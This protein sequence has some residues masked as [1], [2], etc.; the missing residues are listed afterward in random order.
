MMRYAQGGGGWLKPQEMAQRIEAANPNASPR[1]KFYAMKAAM[2]LMTT[3]GQEQFN[4]MMQV[5]RFQQQKQQHEDT[6]HQ[7][8][9]ME[10]H[11]LEAEQLREDRYLRQQPYAQQQMQRAR[12]ATKAQTNVDLRMDK[13]AGHI[14]ALSEVAK[15]VAITG[16]VTFDTWLANAR[17][18]LGWPSDVYTQYKTQLAMLQAEM[19]AMSQQ[20]LGSLTVSAREDAKQLANGIL[21][22]SMLRSIG[23]AVKIEGTIT[24]EASK[25]IIDRANRNFDSYMKSGGRIPEDAEEEPAAAAPQAQRPRAADDKGNVVE[26][27][28]QNWVPVPKGP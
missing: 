27:D 9:R 2:G 28:G 8:E 24:K 14:A 20:T 19:G 21:T 22:P 5:M 3:G 18:A 1:Q 25:K 26:W 11:R 17:A 6:L 16:N 13:V 12:D 4:R 7:Q 10:R 23:E 15:K